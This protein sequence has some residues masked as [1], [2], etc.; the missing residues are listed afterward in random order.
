MSMT[1]LAP[2]ICCQDSF[3]LSRVGG[4]IVA[5]TIGMGMK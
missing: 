5:D 4:Q 1:V 3:L 2:A